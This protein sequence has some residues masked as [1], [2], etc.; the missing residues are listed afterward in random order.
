MLSLAERQHGFAEAILNPDLPVPP[1]LAD[2][3]G[4][5]CADRFAVHRN[6]VATGLVEALRSGFPVVDRL[7]GHEFFSAMAREHA[8]QCPPS[9][10]VLLAYGDGFPDFIAG[11]EPAADLPYLADVARL[12]WLWLEA[13]HAAEAEPLTIAGLARIPADRLPG[14][15]LT[16]HPATRFSGFAHPASTVWRLHQHGGVPGSIE[17]GDAAE[18]VLIVRPEADVGAIPISPG[19]L[20]FLGAVR[21]GESIAGAVAVAL[22]EEARLDI[23]A[24]LRLLFEAGAFAGFAHSDRTA[25]PGRG[26]KK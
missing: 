6:N 26:D 19:I 17:L 24:M 7:V 20:R 4:S 2:P 1:G 3:H 12:E 13:Y 21:G 11:F 22:E 25:E 18:H 14:L 15:L 8:F 23:G 10:P 5:A 9:S 16:L